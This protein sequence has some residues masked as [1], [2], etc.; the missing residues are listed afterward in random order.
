MHPHVTDV[1]DFLTELFESGLSY[2]AINTARSALSQVTIYG[3]GACTIGAHP[4]V[5][6]FMKG[7]FNLRKPVPRYTVTWDVGK[8]LRKVQQLMPLTSLSL[9]ELTLKTAVLVAIVLAARAQT[10][11]ALNVKNMTV[12]HDK[13]CFTLDTHLKQSRPGYKSPLIE[14]VSYSDKSMCVYHTLSEYLK[15]TN[16]LRGSDGQIFI[17]FTKPHRKVCA[18]TV[19]RWIK[20]I[21]SMAGI[22]VKDYTAHSVRAAAT[23]RASG[24]GVPLDEI[25]KTAGWTNARTFAKHYQKPIKKGPNFAEVVI[26]GKKPK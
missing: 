13:F 1:L 3:D 16:D 8:L 17:S 6:K 9:K 20:T 23:S 14:L 11:V 12:K 26:S 25:M 4:W 15:R 21:M 5:T 7:V 2:S 24:L 19:A 22:N 18:E 10:M